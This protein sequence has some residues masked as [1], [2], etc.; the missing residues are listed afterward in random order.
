[1]LIDM[2]TVNGRVYGLGRPVSS[3][4]FNLT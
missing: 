3:L 1:M 2:N 4:R